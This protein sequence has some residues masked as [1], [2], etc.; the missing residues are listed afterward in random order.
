MP[1]SGTD[2]KISSTTIEMITKTLGKKADEPWVRDV[3][4]LHKEDIAEAKDIALA[5]KHK[6][7]NRECMQEKTIDEMMKAINGFKN[8]K[9]AGVISVIVIVLGW[10]SQFFAL[11][12]KVD[13]TADSMVNVEKSVEVIKKASESNSV[14]FKEHIKKVEEEKK[15]EDQEEAIQQ[16]EDKKKHE[17]LLKAIKR[18]R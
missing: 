4:A 18:R 6:F 13:D 10:A 9:L 7:E 15:I 16:K 1:P 11:Q 3:M 5:V 2:R 12:D 17:E 8:V 14:M